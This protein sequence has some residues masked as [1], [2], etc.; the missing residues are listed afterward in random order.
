MAL[1]DFI[2]K[3][4]IDVIDWVEDG[5]Q[6][7]AWRFPMADR[8]IQTGAMLAA[9]EEVFISQKPDRVLVYGDCAV[10]PDPTSEQLADIA[11]SSAA[12]TPWLVRP[13]ISVTLKPMAPRMVASAPLRLPPR[14]Q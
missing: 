3:Q 7:L 13:S 8:E 12:T 1:I 11:I 4:F 2:K 10:I 5:D 9:I 14:Q 6:L